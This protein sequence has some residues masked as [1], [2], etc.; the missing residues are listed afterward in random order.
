MRLAAGCG[1]PDK[2]CSVQ[3]EPGNPT[4]RN[5]E[6][7]AVEAES[8]ARPLRLGL[9]GGTFDPIHHGHLILARDA[10]ERLGL[11]RIVFL[12]AAISPHKLERAPAPAEL[13]GAMVAAAIADEPRFVMDDSELRRSGP[14]FT[15]DSV[16]QIRAR[17]PEAHLHYLIGADNLRELHTWRRIDELRRL[18]QFV[19]FGRGRENSE[20]VH[21]FPILPRRIDI[22]ATE[23]RAR[24]ARGISIRYLVPD[25][26]RLIIASHHLYQEPPHQS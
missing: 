22:S 9:Y 12:P 10:I 25:P 5:L 7:R 24:V 26:V 16:E 6:L 15:I 19:V 14:S 13:R 11:D 2:G 8:G 4:S 21:D 3:S 18:V 23:V 17:H 1:M 20:P